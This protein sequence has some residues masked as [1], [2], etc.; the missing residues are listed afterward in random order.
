MATSSLRKRG[1]EQAALGPVKSGSYVGRADPWWIDGWSWGE[2]MVRRG[3][4]GGEGAD[5]T[6]EDLSDEITQFT[7]DQPD[8]L[9]L[10]PLRLHIDLLMPVSTCSYVGKP[11]GQIQS[12]KYLPNAYPAP[13]IV[14]GVQ[15]RRVVLSVKSPRPHCVTSES[16]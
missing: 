10:P 5:G 15:K 1:E 4:Y 7:L 9:S 16:P 11:H 8:P 3:Q 12:N 14:L 6:L 13:G 2:I